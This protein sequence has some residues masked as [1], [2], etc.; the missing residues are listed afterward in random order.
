MGAR[1]SRPFSARGEAQRVDEALAASR[2]GVAKMGVHILQDAELSFKSILNKLASDVVKA[3]TTTAAAAP[4]AAAKGIKQSNEDEDTSA[5][6]R[7][8]EIVKKEEKEDGVGKAKE[9]EK[10]KSEKNSSS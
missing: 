3:K 6:V 10:G 4:A 2:Y 1:H 7:G 8:E 5:A 9:S